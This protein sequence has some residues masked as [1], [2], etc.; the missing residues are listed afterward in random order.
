M[1]MHNELTNFN[2]FSITSSL[3]KVCFKIN[4]FYVEDFLHEYHRNK[5]LNL[6][7]LIFLRGKMIYL[8]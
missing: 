1:I 7:Y 4:T 8:I 5:Q 2:H 6:T 3:L